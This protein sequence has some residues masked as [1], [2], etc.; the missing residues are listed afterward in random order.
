MKVYSI[1]HDVDRFQFF[2][3]ADPECKTF[4]QLDGSTKLASWE[5]PEVFILEPKYRA[6]NFY[7]A[8][9]NFL[10]AD[11][12][13]AEALRPLLEK[14][15]ELLPLEYK[16]RRFTVLNVT[17]VVD[18]LDHDKSEWRIGRNGNRVLVNRYAFRADLLPPSPIFKLPIGAR[19]TTLL[20]EGLM[21][22]AQELREIVRREGLK[23]LRF[24]ELWDSEVPGPGPSWLFNIG[25]EA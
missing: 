21:D 6:G 7:N 19:T 2:L 18:C 3:P 1:R 14:A 15:G 16:G 12:R 22:P 10:I 4:D 25:Q 8:H 9:G 11:E 5:P 23:G 17:A 24:A 20:T 13:A